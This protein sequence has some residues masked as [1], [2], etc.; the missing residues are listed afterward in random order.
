MT[1]KGTPA[2]LGIC[3]TCKGEAIPLVRRD[4]GLERG[5]RVLQAH[6]DPR[7]GSLTCQGSGSRFFT[8]TS[9]E[10][11]LPAI[12]TN[13]GYLYCGDC[14]T[15]LKDDFKAGSFPLLPAGSHV[16]ETCDGC[17]R[18]VALHSLREA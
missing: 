3:G 1:F 9:P 13:L 6:T 18:K 14:R 16:D 7:N 15:K 17:G 12:V 2:G 5:R 10:P 11:T 8:E 4:G